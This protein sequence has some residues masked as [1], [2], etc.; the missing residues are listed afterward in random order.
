MFRS[1]CR[2]CSLKNVFSKISQN[3]QQNTCVRVSFLIQLQDETYNFIKKETLAQV[4]SSE[5][6]DIFE[7]TFFYSTP[8]VAASEHCS[9]ALLSTLVV[10]LIHQTNCLF[11]TPETIKK[12]LV[13]VKW[14]EIG[15][16]LNHGFSKHTF[17]VN[18]KNKKV[19][20]VNHFSVIEFFFFFKISRRDTVSLI[21]KIA[22]TTRTDIIRR[23]ITI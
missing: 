13:K 16:L 23:P 2:K 15:Y 9:I 5:L 14:H 1:S 11:C 18:S 20:S 19:F 21:R 3:S 7:K 4:F 12:L 10:S 8:P 17:I 6:C 22:I